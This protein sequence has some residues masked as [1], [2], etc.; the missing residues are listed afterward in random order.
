MLTRQVDALSPKIKAAAGQFP[1]A[2]QITALSGKTTNLFQ[3]RNQGQAPNAMA[4]HHPK[5]G[6]AAAGAGELE[7]FDITFQKIV[8]KWI[9][10]GKTAQDDWKIPAIGGP[11]RSPSLFRTNRRLTP[12][13]IDN[14]N[15]SSPVPPLRG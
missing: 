13:S 5:H 6:A 4:H 1:P 15:G 11:I 2:V 8:V 10:G 14:A 3:V 12:P 9:G 7:E